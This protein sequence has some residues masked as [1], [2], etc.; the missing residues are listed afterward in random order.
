MVKC[1]LFTCKEEDQQK[2]HSESVEALVAARLR[3]LRK[4]RGLSLRALAEKS[5]L[6]INT[7][8]L[9]EHEKS[10]PS[11]STLQQL[12]QALGVT[13]ASLLQ[14]SGMENKLVYVQAGC[15]PKTKSG[16]SVLET[17]GS[18]LDS[19]AVQPFVLHLAPGEGSGE[20]DTIHTGHEFLFGL[21][22]SVQAW[23]DG[24]SFVINPGDSLLF[25]AFL[26]HRWINTNK[27]T[28]KILLLMCPSDHHE[29]LGGRHFDG[30]INL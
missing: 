23:V 30:L 6:N 21:E 3:E 20:T 11:I 15:R 24:Q 29:G 13:A 28:A 17:L 5:G 22:G 7:L 19:N 2:P 16:N 1:S 27:E 10:S 9:I 25:E 26:P 4:Q 14:P 18:G 8:S 12:A